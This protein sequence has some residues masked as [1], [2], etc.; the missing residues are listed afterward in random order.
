MQHLEANGL[1]IV[2]K[3]QLEHLA[4]N[5]VKTLDHLRAEYLRKKSLTYKQALDT[6]LLPVTTKQGI[7]SYISTGKIKPN[8][9]YVSANG[10]RMLLTSCIKRLAQL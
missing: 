3:T 7:E 8:E 1:V 5:P 10:R 2:S 6:K 9:Y 4:K